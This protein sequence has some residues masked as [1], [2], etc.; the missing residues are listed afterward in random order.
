MSNVEP[1]V[2]PGIYCPACGA[3]DIVVTANKGGLLRC[4]Y[5]VCPDP[6]ALEKVLSDPRLHQHIVRLDEDGWTV[7]HPLI[8]RIDDRL[9]TC[10]LNHYLSS[11]DVLLNAMVPGEYVAK[12]YDGVAYEAWTLEMITRG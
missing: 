9:F 1:A 4:T 7:R 8:E 3:P 11:D 2:L 6:R 10:S 5:V 12:Q